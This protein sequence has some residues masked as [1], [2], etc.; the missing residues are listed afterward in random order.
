MNAAAISV[1]YPKPLAVVAIPAAC[2]VALLPLVDGAVLITDEGLTESF[3]NPDAGPGREMDDVAVLATIR[4]L[5][6]SAADLCECGCHLHAN[7]PY[8]HFAG[9]RIYISTSSVACF[10]LLPCCM[11]CPRW[12]ATR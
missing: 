9:G 5:L 11:Q 4:P 3:T 7:T 6:S 1:C 8:P 2:A 10:L 12:R